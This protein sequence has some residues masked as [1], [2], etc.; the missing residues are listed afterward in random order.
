MHLASKR[1]WSECPTLKKWYLLVDINPQFCWTNMIS[2]GCYHKSA[3]GLEQDHV[4]L[5]Q[6]PTS[7]LAFVLTMIFDCAEFSKAAEDWVQRVFA[8]QLA[9]FHHLPTWSHLPADVK[10]GVQ[11]FVKA[12]VKHHRHDCCAHERFV[13]FHTGMCARSSRQHAHMHILQP[14]PPFIWL[15]ANDSLMHILPCAICILI[16][17]IS[18]LIARSHQ[19]K[20]PLRW[21]SSWHGPL[22]CQQ[23]DVY[24]A[25]HGVAR[26]S[27]EPR[28]W[29]SNDVKEDCVI[30]HQD[31]CLQT[32]LPKGPMSLNNLAYCPN[33]T[34]SML[35]WRLVRTLLVCRYTYIYMCVY[36]YIERDRCTAFVHH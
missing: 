6:S 15:V 11:V 7:Q 21:L 3:W 33:I 12:R 31:R 22:Q 4:M 27:L 25:Q 34:H 19:L 29:A 36:I 35:C 1:I 16:C 30:Q 17:F 23:G 5:D 13:R 2:W 32:S 10:C 9:T 20:P 26:K 28:C 14:H 18:L 8:C 24:A